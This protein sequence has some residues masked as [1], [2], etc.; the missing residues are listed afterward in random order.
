MYSPNLPPVDMGHP[1]D[2]RLT[3]DVPHDDDVTGGGVL[4]AEDLQPVPPGPHRH[5]PL[6]DIHAPLLSA[7]LGIK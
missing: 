1:R 7:H 3:G 4:A 5:L 6:T 2:P